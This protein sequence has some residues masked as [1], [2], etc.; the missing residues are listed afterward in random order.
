MISFDGPGGVLA[1]A[2]YPVYESTYVHFDD[3]E[4]WTD[5]QMFFSVAIHEFGHTLGL[6]HTNAPYSVMQQYYGTYDFDPEFPL[7][8]DDIQVSADL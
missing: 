7:S 5:E 8:L 1:H 4:D 3:A 6:S 2:R